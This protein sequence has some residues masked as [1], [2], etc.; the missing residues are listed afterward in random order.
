MKR[1]GAMIFLAALACTGGDDDEEPGPLRFDVELEGLEPAMLAIHPIEGS[2]DLLAVGGPFTQ[3]GDPALYR[4]S[5]AAWSEVASPPAWEGAAWWSWS[6]AEDDIWVVGDRAQI[7]RGAIGSM[8]I[9]PTNTSTETVFYGVW[10]AAAD[11]VWIVGGSARPPLGPQGVILHWDGSA[12]S[13]VEPTGTASVA[14]EAAMFKVWGT[15]PDDVFVVGAFG[16]AIHWDGSSWTRTETN[17][18]AQLTT[19]HGRASDDVYAVG[20]FNQGIVLHWDGSA[21]TDIAE[22]FVPRISGVYVQPDGPVWVAGDGGYLASWDGNTWTSIDTRVLQ[23][24][25]AVYADA[26]DV[27]G[28]GGIL[29][30]SS[31]PREGFVGRYGR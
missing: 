19:V 11:D 6:A 9:V 10:G 28:V 16:V 22:P 27:Y 29:A 8:S 13:R 25:H 15:G 24:F 20:G 23:Q 17:I 4:K 3:E 12:L 26:I 31:A 2:G 5:G 21:W 7:A 1:Y 18:E 14:L 30:I